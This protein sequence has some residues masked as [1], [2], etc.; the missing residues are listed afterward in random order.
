MMLP[1]RRV[2]TRLTAWAGLLLATAV[3]L[4]AQAVM[5]TDLTFTALETEVSFWG[6]GT[7]QPSEPR[8]QWVDEGIGQLLQASPRH[9]DFL[10]LSAA[11]LAWEAYW[12]EDVPMR[13]QL[14]EQAL[15]VQFSAVQG[16]P[17]Y[18][19][20]WQKLLQYCGIREEC[21]PYRQLAERQLQLLERWN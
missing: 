2:G 19:Q 6:R 15:A 5:R 17:G 13:S 14:Q 3:I 12:S 20:G 18:R 9:P 21:S 10:E 1:S 11:Q 7:Y 16:R 4:Q 8:R